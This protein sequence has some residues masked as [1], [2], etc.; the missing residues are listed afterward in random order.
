MSSAISGC[1]WTFTSLAA[2]ATWQ[3]G[4][5]SARQPIGCRSTMRAGGRSQRPVPAR[6]S[7][8]RRR[9]R[10]VVTVTVPAGAAVVAGL[11]RQQRVDG[12][13]AGWGE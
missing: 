3:P 11:R 9:G 8:P 7:I 1:Q 12:Q 6:Q 2:I 4:A 13:Q 5:T 10:R